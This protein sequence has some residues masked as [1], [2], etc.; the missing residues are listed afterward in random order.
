MKFYRLILLFL[1]TSF[2]MERAIFALESQEEKNFSHSPSHG[3]AKEVPRVLS[4]QGPIKDENVNLAIGTLLEFDKSNQPIYIFID[5]LGDNKEQG[6]FCFNCSFLLYD[7]IKS[8]QSRVI[9]IGEGEVGLIES[10]LLSAGTKGYR[11]ILPHCHIG[12]HQPAI[13]VGAP[14]GS[15]FK[16]SLK[17]AKLDRHTFFNL[18][19]ENTGQALEKIKALFRPGATF[20]NAKEAV[21]LGFVDQILTENPFTLFEKPV[22]APSP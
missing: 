11:F 4:L 8:L 7:V 13:I 21:A 20:L 10:L 19:S 15:I 9:T 6:E 18:I 3:P 22:T 16:S 2:S 12:F 5:S 14:T 1:L 17:E